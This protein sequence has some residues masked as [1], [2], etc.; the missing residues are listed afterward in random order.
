MSSVFLVAV[1]NVLIPRSHKITLWFPSL[2]I[3]SAEFKGMVPAFKV[4]P[5]D[6]TAAGDVYC[7]TL[8][9]RLTEGSTLKEA[10]EFA[11]AAAAIAVTRL[12][13]QTSAPQRYEIDD[14]LLNSVKT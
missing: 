3:Y 1:S 8:A 14:F 7:G 6:T 2:I 5:V 10:V 9:T 13:A 12:G 11:S 4:N